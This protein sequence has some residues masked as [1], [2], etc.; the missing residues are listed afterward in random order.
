[1][2]FARLLSKPQKSNTRL[3]RSFRSDLP[4][5]NMQ[6]VDPKARALYARVPIS[7]IWA[8]EGDVAILLVFT[9]RS[10]AHLVPGKS[11]W[12]AGRESHC[13]E[14]RPRRRQ[15]FRLPTVSGTVLRA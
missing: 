7:S 5:S 9:A 14:V 6:A 12:Q 1:V 2:T 8:I 13:V 11:S 10:L 4:G 15:S 3:G